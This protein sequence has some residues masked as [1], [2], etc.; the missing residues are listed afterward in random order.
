MIDQLTDQE[1][2]LLPSDEEVEFYA[3]H[4][5]FLTQKLFTD[6]EIDALVEASDRF[7]AGDRDRLL[8]VRPPRLAYWEP[9]NGDVQRHN[10]YVHYESD[11]I[12]RILRKPLV[13]AVAARLAQTYEIRVFRQGYAAPVLYES[14]IPYATL[15]LA[16]RREMVRNAQDGDMALPPLS[17]G[18]EA[19]V[20]RD[21][22]LAPAR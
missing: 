11:A 22:F 19:S 17:D 21:V 20:R 8:P 9:S 14:D 1:R 12:A 6:A 2:E 7:Y 16:D 18:G 5:W 4:G 15:P 13:G 10:D 3:E